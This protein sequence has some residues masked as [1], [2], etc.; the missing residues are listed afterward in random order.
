MI[1]EQ[2]FGKIYYQYCHNIQSRHCD[3]FEGYL[4]N[5]GICIILLNH[6]GLAFNCLRNNARTL[7]DIVNLIKQN[8][9]WQFH[10][11]TS[12]YFTQNVEQN[13]L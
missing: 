8:I 4:G 12:R 3:I 7:N 5:T 1:I 6:N 10:K 9:C 2:I 13:F 11:I